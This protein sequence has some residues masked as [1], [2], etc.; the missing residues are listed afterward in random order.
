ML[1]MQDARNRLRR[2]GEREDGVL[3]H[4][5]TSRIYTESNDIGIGKNIL[6]ESDRQLGMAA[7]TSALRRYALEV[8]N[9]LS[10]FRSSSWYKI[11]LLC[12]QVIL[13]S[14][15]LH[16]SSRAELEDY[17]RLMYARIMQVKGSRKAPREAVRD[18][19]LFLEDLY[20]LYP[21]DK[22]K[23]S[24]PE[25]G[26]VLPFEILLDD[27]LPCEVEVGGVYC[28]DWFVEM[29]NIYI[30]EMTGLVKQVQDCRNRDLQRGRRI[31]H[32]YEIV[33]GL[34]AYEDGNAGSYSSLTYAE[35]DSILL[36]A[37][38]DLEKNKTHVNNIF[39]LLEIPVKLT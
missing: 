29:L 10:C 4:I 1:L 9:L 14:I 6:K 36:D 22:T 34:V 32:D 7:Y 25:G 38:R 35:T 11:C 31:I 26:D 17:M 27:I 12:K 23:P 15:L 5:Q 28:S 24:T 3:N 2:L 37:N 13:D 20:S 19:S 8:L 18:H 21:S 39:S 30:A 33:Q 16:M